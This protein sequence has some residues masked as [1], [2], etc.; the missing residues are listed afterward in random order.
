MKPTSAAGTLAQPDFVEPM[1]VYRRCVPTEQTDRFRQLATGGVRH[2]RPGLQHLDLL[3][4]AQQHDAVAPQDPLAL[5]AAAGGS[6]TG[7]VVV[8]RIGD[9][10][11]SHYIRSQRQTFLFPWLALGRNLY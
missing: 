2:H 1:R 11:R 9:E 7:P 5:P 6:R 8:P 10:L 3:V 4:Q